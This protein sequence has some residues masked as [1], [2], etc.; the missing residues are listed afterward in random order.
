MLVQ[1][2]CLLQGTSGFQTEC[3]SRFEIS[4]P[5]NVSGKPIDGRLLLMLSR[6][7]EF[8]ESGIEDGSP[9]FGIDVNGLKPGENAVIDGS[10]FGQPLTSLGEIPAGEY[11]VKA[12]LNVYTTFHRS[13]G[14][15]VKLHM[16]QGEGQVWYQSPGNFFSKP[17][18]IKFDPAKDEVHSIELA[19]I[20]PPLPEPVDTEWVHT[21]KIRSKRVSEFW[22]CDIHVGAKVLLPKGYHENT[23]QRYPL[24]IQ[25]GH[26]SREN[27]GRF[28]EP[29]E[30]EEGNQFY[31]HWTSD[32]FPRFILVT[33]QHATPYYDC[34]YAVNSKNIGPYGDAMNYE[35]LPEIDRRYRTLATPESRGL[36]GC[37]TGGWEAIATQIWYPELYG[38]TWVLAPDQIDFH[39]YELINLYE[40]E[41]NA[42]F[43]ENEWSKIPLPA[44]RGP[45]GRPRFTNIQENLREEVIGTRYRSGGQWAV[46]N[47]LFCPVAEDG[48]PQSLWDPMTGKIDPE[49][50]KWA[51]ENYDLVHYLK[52]N[53]KEV[54]PKLQGKFTFITGRVD[55]WYI[56]QAVYLMEEYLKSTSEPKSDAK[57]IYGDL[58]E[59]C[60]T[61]WGD[62]PGPM[63]RE[64][65]NAIIENSKKSDGSGSLQDQSNSNSNSPCR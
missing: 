30:G 64:I 18:K 21:F 59:H 20:I 60:W 29:Q 49:V 47:A 35:L 62:E 15:T 24:V 33:I 54:G 6:S 23:D 27:P 40:P 17:Q 13:D 65:G 48:Y 37:S 61:P 53:W 19:N 44:H 16:D 39:Y 51:I 2:T 11:F 43:V 45:D 10:T 32:D 63:F 31:K 34:S 50:A 41:K 5:E 55:N 14:H 4:F 8:N 22:G 12:I 25:H 56:E 46:W 52:K 28:V 9:I 1:G 3:K 26:H 58:G 42:Y 38:K 36:V 7:D 57:F